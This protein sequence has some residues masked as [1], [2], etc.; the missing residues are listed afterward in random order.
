[1]NSQT[2]HSWTNAAV[3]FTVATLLAGP[4]YAAA[5]QSENNISQMHTSQL[6]GYTIEENDFF[7]S[8]EAARDLIQRFDS[9]SK[10][11]ALP[12]GVTEALFLAFIKS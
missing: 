12:D 7:M 10:V 1:M 2:T 6:K 4:A 11:S 8:E 5:A 9:G 3:G